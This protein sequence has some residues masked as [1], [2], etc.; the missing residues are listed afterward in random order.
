M[1]L[2]LLSFA[3]LLVGG[4]VGPPIVGMLA[5]I[6]GTLIHAKLGWWHAHL[7]GSGRR[8]LAALWP[9]VFGIALISGLFLFVGATVLVYAFG[10]GNEDL[11]LNSFFLTV[12]CVVLAIITGIAHDLPQR[13][14][15]FG[16]VLPSSMQGS[17]V[18]SVGLPE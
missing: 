15:G 14:P 11:Y 16:R 8:L 18:P 3:M 5:G 13:E 6:A 17:D 1:V 10:W 7:T 12:V 4:G 2:I 9:W